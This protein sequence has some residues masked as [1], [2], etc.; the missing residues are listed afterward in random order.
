MAFPRNIDPAVPA[1]TDLISGGDNELRQLKQ[2]LID[3]FGLPSASNI[4]A[5]IMD[6]N[7]DGTIAALSEIQG[8]VTLNRGTTP[9]GALLVAIAQPGAAGTRDSHDI[10]LRGTSF[11]SAGHNADWK[12]FVDVTS[13]AGASIWLLQSR[14]DAASFATRLAVTD[15]GN[16]GLGTATE[17]GSGVVV[18][19]VANAT[20][21][22]SANPTGGAAYYAEGGALKCRG[23]GGTI[24]TIAPA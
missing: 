14:V 1:G 24:T 23:S 15:Q 22:P 8:L 2:D 17:F 4:T 16:L 21:V 11:D 20:T 10:T 9:T 19:G 13:N 7:A 12:S 3:L 18:G 6:I 5:A